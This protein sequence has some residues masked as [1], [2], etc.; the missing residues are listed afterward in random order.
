MDENG[1]D[2]VKNALEQMASLTEA[3]D[4]RVRRA[5]A[6]EAQAGGPLDP[7]LS[8]EVRRAHRMRVDQITMLNRIGPNRLPAATPRSGGIITQILASL[9]S[10]P[11][12][13]KHGRVSVA[14][15]T[16]VGD[17]ASDR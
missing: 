17:P 3:Q 8:T 16:R 13:P 6:E 14:P 4:A 2:P 7:A 1:E 11:R 9:I 5:L 12:R 15:H 10:K